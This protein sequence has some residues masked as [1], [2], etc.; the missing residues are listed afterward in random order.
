MSNALNTII[1]QKKI[2]VKSLKQQGLYKTAPCAIN[3]HFFANL[4]SQ[5]PGIIAEIKKGSPSKGIIRPDFDVQAIAKAYQHAGAA[6]LSVLTDESF[7]YGAL[8]NLALAKSCCDLPLLRKDFIIDP[9]QIFESI[10]HQASAILLIVAA[11]DKSQLFDLY[12]TAHELGLDILVECHN[13]SEVETALELP[14]KAIGINNRNLKTFETS[15]ET[16]LTLQRYL[17]AELP[18]ITESGI[19]TAED[20]QRM[21]QSGINHFLIGEAF[22]RHPSPDQALKELLLKV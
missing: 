1:E 11:L 12:Q 17:P 9:I 19:H 16:T 22:M 20:V 7:F 10:E 2:E 6:A 13:A 3:S 4:L 18:V 5:K 15:L 8:K 21:Q 14:L